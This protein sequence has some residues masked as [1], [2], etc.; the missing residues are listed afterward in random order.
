MVTTL[1]QESV[2]VITH[3]QKP[4]R[5]YLL[6]HIVEFPTKMLYDT[7][8]DICC[9]SEQIF[10]QLKAKLPIKTLSP[11][12]QFRSAGGQKLQVI[13]KY[14]VPIKIGKKEI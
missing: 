8:A 3:H 14:S 13:G 12:K 6:A 4:R 9:L 7:G 1:L 11:Q 2:S 10:N 5:P